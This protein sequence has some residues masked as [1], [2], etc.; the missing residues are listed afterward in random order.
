MAQK[1][2]YAHAFLPA[3]RPSDVSSILRGRL[4]SAEVLNS[5]IADWFHERARIEELYS[6]ELEKLSQRSVHLLE[7]GSLENVWKDLEKSTRESSRGS[8]VFA[9]RIRQDVEQPIRQFVKTTQWTDVKGLHD[10][11]DSLAE[12][13]SS[14]EQQ[15]EKLH[16]K[17]GKNQ[18]QMNIA[19]H[20]LD[21]TRSQ[22][23]S[24]APY[25]LEQIQTADEG[26]LAYLKSAL[27]TFVTVEEDRYKMSLKESEVILNSVLSFE[28]SNEVSAFANQVERGEATSAMT[29]PEPSAPKHKLVNHLDTRHHAPISLRSRTSRDSLGASLSSSSSKLRFKV[30]SLFRT[31]KK[32]N[33]NI[34]LSPQP[35]SDTREPPVANGSH[36][37]MIKESHIPEAIQEH[38]KPS[39]PPPRKA[40]VDHSSHIATQIN[41]DAR[42]VTTPV[43]DNDRLTST[44]PANGSDTVTPVNGNHRVLTSPTSN[45]HI[46]VTTPPKNPDNI[47]VPF[48][49]T[50][51]SQDWGS[52]P[53]TVPEE[54]EESTAGNSLF[55]I[56]IKPKAIATT[57]RD[58]DDIALSVVASQLRSKNTIS[59]RSQQKRGRRDIQS[60]L[61]TNIGPSDIMEAGNGKRSPRSPRSLHSPSTLQNIAEIPPASHLESYDSD[62]SAST[63]DDV[64]L[65]SPTLVHPAMPLADQDMGLS[66]T[67]SEVVSTVIK[68]GQV[69]R[70]QIVGEV[71]LSYTG[72][73]TGDESND[74]VRV[75]IGNSK[76]FETLS[77]NK[78]LV[79]TVDQALGIYSINTRLFT[80]GTIAIAGGFK[81]QS[82][83]AQGFVPI[84]FTPIWRIEPSQ[85][86]LML[87]YKVSNQFLLQ[88]PI[89]LHDLVITVPVEGGVA[90]SA[91]SKP[92]AMFN[93]QKQQM[94]WRYTD[95]V[96]VEA[97]VEHMLLGRFAVDE[98][99]IPVRESA[100]G[101][102]VSFRVESSNTEVADHQIVLEQ[103]QGE[104]D[105]WKPVPTMV[106]ISTGRFVVHSEDNVQSRVEDVQ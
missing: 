18:Q 67:I 31:S 4:G 57:T 23:E 66:A 104:V 45:N 78:T 11:F 102:L 70:S 49:F 2:Q 16:R 72:N 94:V 9:T 71:A 97:G 26:R 79:T 96:V 55:N 95:P 46:G 41:D 80:S 106:S 47:D 60:A 93:R 34:P 62:I 8:Q 35:E 13:Y 77:P 14:Y 17:P 98:G 1:A 90:T 24:Q 84:D 61:F 19:Q 59:S 48:E 51:S 87:A 20:S 86:R 22:W 52:V 54:E 75:R 50:E 81:M 56:N 103:E 101:I 99:S 91:S 5:D 43:N 27:T 7:N 42:S 68:D 65:L 82:Q 76:A 83:N 32:K 36:Q 33:N 53:T 15:L 25:V 21:E 73:S 58:E 74:S 38:V 39:P 28:P 29:G 105:E 92:R 12:S 63:V 40:G 88:S 100:K 44:P 89:T 3:Y 37:N 6:A 10:M 30:G 69:V 64:A 85:S